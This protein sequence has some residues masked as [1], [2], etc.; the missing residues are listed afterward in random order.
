[1]ADAVR[2]GDQSSLEQALRLVTRDPAAAT[3]LSM[4]NHRWIDPGESRA[5]ARDALITRLK[6]TVPTGSEDAG[7]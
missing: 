2:R 6:A 3:L 5:A 4:R 7:R 1:M